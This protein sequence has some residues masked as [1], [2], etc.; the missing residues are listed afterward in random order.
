MS[1]ERP[2][3]I[4]FGRK[5]GAIVVQSAHLSHDGCRSSG[6]VSGIPRHSGTFTFMVS[7]N[8]RHYNQMLHN[9]LICLSYASRG[10]VLCTVV[11]TDARLCPLLLLLLLVVVVAILV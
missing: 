11:S 3:K 10:A 7:T 5:E 6:A 4:C 8:S 2:G 9:V 1:N